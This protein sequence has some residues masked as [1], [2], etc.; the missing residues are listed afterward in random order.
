MKEKTY[1]EYIA[2]LSYLFKL[3]ENKNLSEKD[4]SIKYDLF[5]N[6]YTVNRCNDNY[7][8]KFN[9]DSNSYFINPIL[10]MKY[11]TLS[12]MALHGNGLVCIE[13]NDATVLNSL[14]QTSIYKFVPQIQPDVYAM[15]NAPLYLIPKLNEFEFNML[16]PDL[17]TLYLNYVAN[18]NKYILEEKENGM[19]SLVLLHGQMN[20]NTR[21]YYMVDEN[22]SPLLE[23]LV[24]AYK[25]VSEEDYEKIMLP[26]RE[27]SKNKALRR[28]RS[29][30]HA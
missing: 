10:S 9:L 3:E 4:I 5:T 6:A 13:V 18:K 29:K 22:Y 17:Q 27:Q 20:N 30:K 24:S 26:A 14:P 21:Q 25:P 23:S 19:V 8:K 2:Y 15:E 28:V 11:R 7:R 16:H 1:V 12:E